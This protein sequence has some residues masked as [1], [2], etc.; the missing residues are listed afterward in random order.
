M[1]S[2]SENII[3]AA[4]AD[5]S[6]LRAGRLTDADLAAMIKVLI[7]ARDHIRD[8][9]GTEDRPDSDSAELV[10]KINAVLGRVDNPV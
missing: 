1:A 7:A 6:V 10:D 4:K 3:A 9:F 8:C 2:S 5:S